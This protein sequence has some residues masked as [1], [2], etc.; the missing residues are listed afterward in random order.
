[1]S[2]YLREPGEEYSEFHELHAASSPSD[3][4]MESSTWETIFGGGGC[5]KW[6]IGWRGG[7]RHVCCESASV[8]KPK[9]EAVEGDGITHEEN[10]GE[11]HDDKEADVEDDGVED[12]P[13]ELGALST[14]AS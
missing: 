12:A 7:R 5:S 2:A 11:A 4:G 6:G 13:T 3:R 10:Q 9:S 8:L 1:M 14:F